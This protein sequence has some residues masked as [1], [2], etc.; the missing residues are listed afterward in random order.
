LFIIGGV[1]NLWM[2]V[3]PIV[4]LTPKEKT[5]LETAAS[6]RSSAVRLRERAATVLLA[7]GG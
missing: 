5:R 1:L 3:A 7:A 4:T 2:R 6:A